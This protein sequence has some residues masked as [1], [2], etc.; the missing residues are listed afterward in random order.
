MGSTQSHP[1]P[2]NDPPQEFIQKIPGTYTSGR[3]IIITGNDKISLKCDCIN[4]SI[5]NG[6]GE[7]MLFT[8]VLSLPPGQ[9]KYKKL[10]K[11]LS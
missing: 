1:G 3:H 10:R 7:R 2:L 9:K 4:G 6:C 11:K 5:N 8:F